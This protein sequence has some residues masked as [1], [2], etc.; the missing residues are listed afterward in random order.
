VIDVTVS[1][2][3]REDEAVVD[4]NMVCMRCNNW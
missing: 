1:R 2:T 4:A 3:T